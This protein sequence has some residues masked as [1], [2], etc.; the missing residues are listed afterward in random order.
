MKSTTIDRPSSPAARLS[1]TDSA[2]SVEPTWITSSTWRSTGSDPA[3]MPV[4]R[5]CA[6][7]CVKPPL[8][9]AWPPAIS[10]RVVGSVSFFPQTV[11]GV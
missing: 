7:A 9:T 1:L 11:S 3:L 5:S 2:P 6:L 4:A 8:I 10:V